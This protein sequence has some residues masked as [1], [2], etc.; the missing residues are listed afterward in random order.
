[1]LQVVR[2]RDVL[3][4]AAAEQ[5]RERGQEAGRVAERP[6]G[7]E[8]ELEE[9]LAQE[10]D[11]LGPRQHA[12][13]G[14]QAE[15]QGVLADQAVAEGVERG[16]GRVRVAVRDQLVDADGHLLGGLVGERQGEDLRRPGPTSGDQPGDPPGDDLRLA[17]ARARH[18]QQR[19]VAMGDR[20]E[21]IGIEPA[22]ERLEPGRRVAAERRI[23]DRHELAPGRQLLEGRWFAAAADAR[24]AHRAVRGDGR[25]SRGHVESIARGRAT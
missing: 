18:D 23:H 5:R 1:M 8:L 24:R 7:V 25:G 9:V 2:R 20:P 15:L 4:L 21:L 10:D 6:V 11:D 16:D 19:T 13:V 17:G 12:Q 14:R 22:E 3:V